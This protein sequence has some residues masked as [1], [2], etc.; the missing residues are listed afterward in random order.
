[1]GSDYELFESP[2]G[3]VLLHKGTPIFHWEEEPSE[4]AVEI[5]LQYTQGRR[6]IL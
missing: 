3:W 4:R 2:R 6:V 1:M 5:A